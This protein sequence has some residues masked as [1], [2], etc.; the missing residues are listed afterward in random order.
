MKLYVQDV[1]FSYVGA[2]ALEHVT[3]CRGNVPPFW[4]ETVRENPRCSA[5]L[6]AFCAVG[7]GG[8]RRTAVRLTE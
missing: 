4:A 3:F 8:L 2:P 7:R 6:T 5:V 1:G